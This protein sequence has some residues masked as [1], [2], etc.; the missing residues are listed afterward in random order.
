LFINLLKLAFDIRQMQPVWG[1][2]GK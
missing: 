1:V 2:P